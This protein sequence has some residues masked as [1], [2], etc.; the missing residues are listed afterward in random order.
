[1]RAAPTNQYLLCVCAPAKQVSWRRT[2]K[3]AS[4]QVSVTLSQGGELV[5]LAAAAL[6]VS[7][8]W[9]Q[10]SGEHR[11][12]ANQVQ[13]RLFFL[14]LQ[15]EKKINLSFFKIKSDSTMAQEGKKLLQTVN[16]DAR[17]IFTC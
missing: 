2:G 5:S 8:D 16:F 10:T 15:R 9:H 12:A 3:R 4:G 17:A 11:A 13:C 7:F 1:M 14:F 6:C